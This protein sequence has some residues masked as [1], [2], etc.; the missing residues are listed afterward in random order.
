MITGDMIEIKRT[1]GGGLS[2]IAPTGWPTNKQYRDGKWYI[3]VDEV[4]AIRLYRHSTR[5][6]LEIAE[7]VDLVNPVKVFRL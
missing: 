2:F 6:C 7:R 3:Y 4:G 5:Q 1:D